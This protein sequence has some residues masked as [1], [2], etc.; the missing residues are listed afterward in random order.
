MH[1]LTDYV[2]LEL[3]A[4]TLWPSTARALH[5]YSEFS[6]LILVAFPLQE[7]LRK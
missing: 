1:K 6:G 7:E 4:R 5:E 3:P 2:H